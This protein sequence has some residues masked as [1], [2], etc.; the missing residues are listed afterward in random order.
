MGLTGKDVTRLDF[1]GLEGVLG[2]HPHLALEDTRPA[3]PASD[4]PAPAPDALDRAAAV[5]RA[6]RSTYAHLALVGDKA[7]LFNA[8]GNAFV[9]FAGEGRSLVAMGDPVGPEEEL[10]ELVW[11]FKGI[12]D[13]YASHMVFYQA[14][15]AHL[16]LYIDAGLAFL[17]LGEEAVI[18][19]AGFSLEGKPFRDLRA[20]RNRA[21][22]DGAAFGIL[23]PAEVEAALPR[24]RDVSRDWLRAK[25]AREKGFSLGY[26]EDD[27]LRRCA[28]AVA[29]VGG[30]IVAFANLWRCAGREELSVDMMRHLA[31][32]PKGI[33]DFLFAEIMARGREEGYARFNL[34]MAPLSGLENREFAPLWAK[35]ASFLYEHGERFYHF[36]GLRRYKEKF[37]PVWE[38]RYLAAPGGLA[39]TRALANVTALIARGPKGALR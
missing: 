33:M 1:G 28:V 16:P 32:A 20:G 10:P 39:M 15:Q 4:M 34:G 21:L 24:L 6:H 8:K 37:G 22:K 25:D 19:L 3:R 17:K 35:A 5:A 13:R 14:T 2:V 26:F 38:P 23:E 30:D 11:T 27:Y 31:D 36:R 7:L 12:C 9:M 29:R 18:P